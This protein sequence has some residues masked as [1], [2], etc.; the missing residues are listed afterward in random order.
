MHIDAAWV[1]GP[2]LRFQQLGRGGQR[3]HVVLAHPHLADWKSSAP[4]GSEQL[5]AGVLHPLQ[6]GAGGRSHGEDPSLKAEGPTVSGQLGS[7]QTGPG[8]PKRREVTISLP[9]LLQ[10]A[11]AVANRFGGGTRSG[12]QQGE[13][14]HHALVLVGRTAWHAARTPRPAFRGGGRCGG[15]EEKCSATP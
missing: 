1:T 7:G 4:Q 14:A 2:D 13:V 3:E 6:P 11:Q 10:V 12:N 9:L 8:Q 5:M 15:H